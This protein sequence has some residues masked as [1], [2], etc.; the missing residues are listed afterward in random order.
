MNRAISVSPGVGAAPAAEPD[1]VLQP[2]GHAAMALGVRF[3]VTEQQQ[4]WLEEM[5][6]SEFTRNRQAF[7][8][9]F[10]QPAHESERTNREYYSFFHGEFHKRGRTMKDV[11]EQGV[12]GF[13]GR[14]RE[15]LRS[16][17]D[18]DKVERDT[19]RAKSGTRI[20]HIWTDK[21]G[22]KIVADRAKGKQFRAIAKELGV[23]MA[24]VKEQYALVRRG[25]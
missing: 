16:Q 10:A 14:P 15:V 23:S 8:D 22:A 5:W 9:Y 20:K 18:A 24:N 2:P 4:A 11:D 13:I 21:Q 1:D 17:A 19:I 25:K 3:P 12:V 7:L 6:E